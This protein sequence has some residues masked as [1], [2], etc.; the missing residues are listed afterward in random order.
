[1]LPEAA[2]PPGV[3]EPSA[4]AG[5]SFPAPSFWSSKGVTFLHALLSIRMG[6]ELF[7]Q[8]SSS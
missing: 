8:S 1:M 3:H 6:G 7:V 2:P 5:T 4:V